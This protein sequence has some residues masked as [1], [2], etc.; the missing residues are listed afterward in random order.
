MAGLPE[1]ILDVGNLVEGRAQ[2]LGW[3]DLGSDVLCLLLR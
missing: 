1:G 2:L 3:R